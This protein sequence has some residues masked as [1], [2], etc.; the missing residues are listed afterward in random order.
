M[1]AEALARLYPDEARARAAEEEDRPRA[2]A[3]QTATLP[4]FL[5][6]SVLPGQEMRLHVFEPRYV[7]LT[8]R[9]L[10]DPSL[11]RRFGMTDYEAQARAGSFGCSVR[12]LEHEEVR[13][14]HYNTNYNL[15]VLGD[16]RFRIHRTRLV[17]GYRSAQV[18][19]AADVPSEEE[20]S[21]APELAESLRTSLGEWQRELLSGHHERFAGQLELIRHNLGPQ[22]TDDLER[23][24]LWGAALINPLPALGVAPEIRRRA[25]ELTSTAARLELVRGACES[26]REYL[27]APTGHAALRMLFHRCLSLVLSVFFGVLRAARALAE[28]AVGSARHP[29]VIAL[30]G[31]LIAGALLTQQEGPKQPPLPDPLDFSWAWRGALP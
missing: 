19:W 16:R 15:R 17:D 22:P 23:L 24:G 20:E 9:V 18:E 13:G 28:L 6:D 1:L 8:R 11:E 26:S 30:A 4:L 3:R 25:L 12:I 31:A 2:S 10:S 21:R 7:A 27:R 29:A 14:R 5:L